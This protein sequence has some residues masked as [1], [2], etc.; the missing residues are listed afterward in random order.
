MKVFSGANSK[1]TQ[2]L[3]IYNQRL[4]RGESWLLKTSVSTEKSQIHQNTFYDRTSIKPV[5]LQDQWGK[6]VNFAFWFRLQQANCNLNLV[7]N[8]LVPPLVIEGEVEQLMIRKVDHFCV[9]QVLSFSVPNFLGFYGE[10]QALMSSWMLLKRLESK[11]FCIWKTSWLEKLSKSH[12]MPYETYFNKMHNHNA[13]ESLLGGRRRTNG[14]LPYWYWFIHIWLNMKKT[15]T[16]RTWEQD[17]ICTSRRLLTQL[18]KKVFLMLVT[19][20]LVVN[21]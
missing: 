7:K 11:N 5:D 3:S 18:W 17:K 4:A 19:M 13:V 12:L 9:S 2:L 16:C 8:N 1:F 14:S 20:W 6:I 21:F 15:G 10:Q